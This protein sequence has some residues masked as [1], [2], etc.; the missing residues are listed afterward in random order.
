MLPLDWFPEKWER[1]VFPHGR[2]RWMLHRRFFD[3]AVF[4]QI[5]R[6]LNSVDLFVED[7]ARFDDYRVHQVSDE[8]LQREL[9]RYSEMVG[10]PLRGK[11]QVKEEKEKLGA[12]LDEVDANFPS[13]DSIEFVNEELVIH[14]PGKEPEPPNRTLIDQAIKATMPQ[15]SILDLL[16]ETEQ[17]L[18]LHK[19][20]G[21]FSGFDA[22]I[23]DP[24][25]R[26]ITTLFCYG[27]NLGPSQTARSVKGL[28]RKQVASLDLKQVTEER[29]DKAIVKVINA[30]NRF[31]LPKFWGS[32]KRASA[33]GTK[34][35]L[36]E[37]N[38]LSEFH[39][40]YGGYG[41][42]GYFHVSDM[43]IALFSH[44]IPRGVHEAVYILDGL[45]R[46]GVDIK[47][48][49]IHGDTHAQSGPVF[50]LAYVLG[51][52]LMPRM[53]N[54]KD[55]VLYKAD[56]RREYKHIDRLCRR[57]I[58]RDLIGR[59]YADMIRVA[60]SIKT[61]KMTPSAILRRLGS[62]IT[63][64]KLYFAFRELGR[65]VRTLFLLKYLNDPELRRTIQA[66]TNKGEQFSDF[67]QWLMF[68][69]E[70]VI[71]ENVR[72][73]QR[74]VIK[75]NRLVANMV[76]LYNVQWMSSKLKELQANGLPVDADVLMVS[77]PYRHEHINRF[78]DY[79]LDLLRNVSP[80]DP[81]I[82]FSFESAA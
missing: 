46:N 80:L 8:E 12:A 75:Y 42:I 9:P 22:K 37:Q 41:S 43:Y 28:S 18:D 59:H 54:I 33:D 64:N 44:F 70:G 52:S 51:I 26:F 67:A 61:G 29:L 14:K 31:A 60:V 57:S 1:A 7:S 58:D 25:K 3:L 66:A 24:R 2:G 69:R 10:L 38:L 35:S 56:K 21:P 76:I 79:L 13:N 32:G 72:H 71:A 16:T 23:D 50:G 74:K 6:E 15:L 68:G 27:C 55:L 48:D 47:P 17:W 73:E 45:I 78:G 81:S 77:S 5:M 19:L 49:T 39:I 11:V 82:E 63:K 53:R 36:F 65:V 20:F 30:Y 34:W 40:R 62:E 4:S